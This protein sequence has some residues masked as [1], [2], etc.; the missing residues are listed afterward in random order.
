L[1]PPAIAG[2]CWR[3]QAGV[4]GWFDWTQKGQWLVSIQRLDWQVADLACAAILLALP[5]LALSPRV[6]IDSRVGLAAA[7]AVAAFLLLPKQIFGSVF[8]DMRLAPYAVLLALLALRDTGTVATRRVVMAAA[9][10]FLGLRLALTAQVYQEREREVERHLSALDAI[11]T[12]AR[13][14]VLV[15][16]PCQ[17]DWTLPWLSHLG[18][19]ALTRKPIFVNDQWANASMNPLRVRLPGAGAFATDDKQLF[20]PARCS[21][22]PTLAQAVRALPLDAF[23]HVWLVGPSPSAIPSHPKLAPVWRS[24]DAAVLRITSD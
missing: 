20:F 1:A 11:P 19:M 16:V 8:A 13:V 6:R 12:H 5:L 2:H 21:M 18:S 22:A 14:A 3:C 17:T 4:D 10:A 15:E 7:L 24:R 9:L 23:T